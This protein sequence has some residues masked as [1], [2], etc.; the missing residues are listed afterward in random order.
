MGSNSAARFVEL[1]RERPSPL[2]SGEKALCAAIVAQSCTDAC[3]P[4]GRLSTG[5]SGNVA[6]TASQQHEARRWLLDDTIEPW[7][8]RWCCDHLDIDVGALRR[9]IAAHIAADGD[10]NGRR[11]H[12]GRRNRHIPERYAAVRELRA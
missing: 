10:L 12:Y 3:W 8:L 6:P 11:L 5:M 4:S 7:G 2:M 1:N 9:R